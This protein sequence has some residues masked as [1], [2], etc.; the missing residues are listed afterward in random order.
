MWIVRY[1]VTCQSGDGG[2]G[3]SF[4]VEIKVSE[5]SAAASLLVFGN[6][7]LG[8]AEYSKL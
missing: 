8:H 5:S 7:H 6:T 3:G 2:F 4:T 1:N